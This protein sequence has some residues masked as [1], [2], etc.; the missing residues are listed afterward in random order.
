MGA[1]L[2]DLSTV[3]LLEKFGAGSHK[4]GSGSAAA[5]QG[6]ISSKLLITV[7]SL[8][9]E[10]KRRAN[11]SE[12][13]PKLLLLKKRISEYIYPELTRFFQEDSVQFGKTIELRKRRDLK[14]DPQIKNLLVK[15][16]LNELK[17]AIQIPIEIA[18]LCIELAEIGDYVFDNAFRGARGDSQVAL[19]GAVSA[20]AGCISI[21]QLNLLSYGSDEYIYGLMRLFRQ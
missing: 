8:T 4:P 16:S 9:N 18:S 3:E 15:E 10:E 7:I 20:I 5:F 12:S 6:M 1:N 13:L 17:V 2:L 21:V 11:Y 14:K 19:S